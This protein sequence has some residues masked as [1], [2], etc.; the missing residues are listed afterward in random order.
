MFVSILHCA[1]FRSLPR[2]NYEL[3]AGA[4]TRR[5][6][7]AAAVAAATR[8]CRRTASGPSDES[9][10]TASQPREAEAASA[11]ANE[12]RAAST[13]AR[14][15]RAAASKSRKPR[16]ASTKPPQPRAAST[17]PRKPRAASTRTRKP[18]AASQRSRSHNPVFVSV[19]DKIEVWWESEGEWYAAEVINVDEGD[20]TYEVRYFTDQTRLWHDSDWEI[21]RLVE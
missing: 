17:K 19:R 2:T 1:S 6:R 13:K 21:R 16:A 7:R 12:P 14:K 15:P 3:A 4:P 10:A 8:M 5:S 20:D 9:Q 18:R 11:P